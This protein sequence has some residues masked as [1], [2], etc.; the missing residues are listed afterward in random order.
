MIETQQHTA[1]YAGSCLASGSTFAG[2][3]VTLGY[4]SVGSAGFAGTG[5]VAEV[6]VTAASSEVEQ[7][8]PI[9]AAVD[10]DLA[11]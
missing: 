1:A 11:P 10:D 8:L 7:E 6:Y 3:T 9:A 2:A 5:G 4:S